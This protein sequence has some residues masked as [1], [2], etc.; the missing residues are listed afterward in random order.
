MNKW[1]KNVDIFIFTIRN[2]ELSDFND[3][4]CLTDETRT[5][6]CFEIIIL[7]H[8]SIVFFLLLFFISSI[9]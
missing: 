9:Y 7:T 3:I 8:T 4:L 6:G 5:S 1:W 2:I